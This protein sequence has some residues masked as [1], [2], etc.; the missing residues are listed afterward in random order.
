MQF[1]SPTNILSDPLI[2]IKFQISSICSFLT[3]S[4]SLNLQHSELLAKMVPLDS[5][6][7]LLKWQIAD[8]ELSKEP[9]IE[10][11]K[12]QLMTLYGTALYSSHTTEHT[13]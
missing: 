13:S 10:G 4:S 2:F 5:T 8:V 3:L 6:L 11:S 12:S 9:F 1:F 7:L